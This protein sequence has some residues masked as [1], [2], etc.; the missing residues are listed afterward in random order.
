[1]KQEPDEGLAVGIT[2]CGQNQRTGEI[3]ELVPS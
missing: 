1:M 3:L 2:Y